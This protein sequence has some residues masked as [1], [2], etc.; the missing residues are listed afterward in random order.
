MGLQYH[1]IEIKNAKLHWKP[2]LTISP[3]NIQR[4]TNYFTFKA[5]L[6]EHITHL[7]L[8]SIEEFYNYGIFME[9]DHLLELCLI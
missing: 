4:D 9:P 5:K 3:V 7:R 1:F 6:K 2:F 8:F